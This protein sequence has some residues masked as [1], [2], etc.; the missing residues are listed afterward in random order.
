MNAIQSSERQLQILLRDVQTE[1]QTLREQLQKAE[2]KEQER[3]QNVWIAKLEIMNN[4][5]KAL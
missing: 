2:L 3:T 1:N 5:K 4:E